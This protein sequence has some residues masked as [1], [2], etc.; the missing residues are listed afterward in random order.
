[1]FGCER[2]PIVRARD[3]DS[4]QVTDVEDLSV[5]GIDDLAR[6]RVDLLLA[7]VDG[8]GVRNH[9]TL[10]GRDAHLIIGCGFIEGA[11]VVDAFLVVLGQNNDT[12][13]VVTVCWAP[14]LVVKGRAVVP[15][16]VL[17]VNDGG[18]AARVEPRYGVELRLHR[19]HKVGLIILSDI[20]EQGVAHKRIHA[21]IVIV[22]ELCRGAI[23]TVG[24]SK[25]RNR[26]TLCACHSQKVC[27]R[28]PR[29]LLDELITDHNIAVQGEVRVTLI[30]RRKI[31]AEG[32][33]HLRCWLQC[34]V[35]SSDD[36]TQRPVAALREVLSDA[37][38]GNVA[39][40]VDIHHPFVCTIERGFV[41][42]LDAVVAGGAAPRFVLLA[43]KLREGINIGDFHVVRDAQGRLL[44]HIDGTGEGVARH[45][46][47]EVERRL[48]FAS[49]EHRIE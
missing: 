26:A 34:A 21:D 3:R 15:G 29:C 12:R 31:R 18:A 45:G 27:A 4:I 44:G 30:P 5:H 11:L 17:A 16:E 25:T 43:H 22:S 42:Q 13:V 41:L 9:G 24:L 8:E 32:V 38:T 6:E 46:R 19:N 39:V 35:L 14:V 23:K 20:H 40:Q 2:L 7:C 10:A 28:V 33:G 1:M 36:V 48:A 49:G 47:R 37:D